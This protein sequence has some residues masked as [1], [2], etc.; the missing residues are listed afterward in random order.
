MDIKILQEYIKLEGASANAEGFYNNVKS[1][2]PSE[3]K[4]VNIEVIRRFF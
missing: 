3:L 4:R 2:Y 1:Y